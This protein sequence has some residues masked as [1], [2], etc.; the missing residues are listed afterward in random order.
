MADKAK[1]GMPRL[2]RELELC[3][4]DTDVFE[5]AVSLAVS[6]M[7]AL[8]RRIRENRDQE[9]KGK[10]KGKESGKG[11]RGSWDQHRSQPYDSK[12]KG[13]GKDGKDKGGRAK[14]PEESSKKD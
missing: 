4:K 8:S 6:A 3:M 7:H 14:G 13:K 10:G 11:Y 5:R 1:H 9:Y 12:G 2:E